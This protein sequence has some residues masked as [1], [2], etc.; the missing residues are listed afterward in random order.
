VAYDP[1]GINVLSDSAAAGK[2]QKKRRQFFHT[3]RL[4]TIAVRM[5]GN[6]RSLKL[7][8]HHSSLISCIFYT[9]KSPDFRGRI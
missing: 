4:K 8:T 1:N 2:E 5:T 3:E 7:I 6:I 9:K